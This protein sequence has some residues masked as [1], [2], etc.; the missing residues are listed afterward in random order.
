[1]LGGERLS[2]PRVREHDA[3]IGVDEIQ[4]NSLVE[5]VAG[6]ELALAVLRRL[7]ALRELSGSGNL[8]VRHKLFEV[9]LLELGR[10]ARLSRRKANELARLQAAGIKGFLI[11][12]TLVRAD[13]P[14]AKLREF[15]GK[16]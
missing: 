13:D 14:G 10:T 7:H 4:R 9:L 3:F 2:I 1:M 5:S 15:L 8:K 16:P 6:S 11:G 12:E